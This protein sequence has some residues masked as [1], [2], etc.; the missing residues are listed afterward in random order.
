MREWLDLLG[1]VWEHG[2]LRENRTGVNAYGVFSPKDVEVW[3][4]DG[5]PAVTTKKLAWKSVVWELLWFLRGETNNNWL[6]H[7]RV[8]IW[9]EWAGEDG[10]LGPVYGAQWRRWPGYDGK[11]IDQI[12]RVIEQIRNEPDSRRIIVNAWNVGQIAEMALPPCHSMFQFWVSKGKLSV[13]VYQRSADVF[14]GVPFNIASYALLLHIIAKLTGTVAERV[15]FTYGDAH[16]YENHMEQA[17]TV[18]A[19]LPYEPPRL[20]LPE[21]S[22]LEEVCNLRADQFVLEGYQHHAEVRGEIA[23]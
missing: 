23:R 20:V 8:T 13:K 12:A 7:R 10:D 21:F 16:L 14:L 1:E 15:I 5:F 19:R 3:M 17:E 4:G 2:E 22:T 11:P 6:R 9:D 18:L